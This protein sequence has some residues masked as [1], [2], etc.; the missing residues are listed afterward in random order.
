[1]ASSSQS[2]QPGGFLQPALPSPPASS[3]NSPRI[4]RPVLPQPRSKPLKPG[5]TKESNFIDHVE[6]KLLAV[7]RRYENRFSATLS[8]EENP[9]IEGRGYKNIGDEVR[10]LDPIVDVVWISGTRRVTLHNCCKKYW[11]DTN[12]P[13]TA[14]LQVA[15]LL[16]IALTVMTSLPSFPF[17]PRPTFQLLQKLDL[18]FASLLRGVNAE[19][20]EALP[21]SETGKS[22]L[23]TT[24]KIR[25]RGIVEKTRLAVVE[26][27]GKDESLADVSNN[28]QSMM[29]D[30][31]DDF[32]ATMTEDEDLDDLEDES[33]HRRWEMDIARVYERTI[34]ELGLALD[35][36]DSGNDNW[37]L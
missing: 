22:R 14:S 8:E 20:G 25:I 7:S 23:S 15:F 34:V 35:V 19:T 17:M 13:S 27:A 21:G 37:V 16:T 5:S 29:T 36:S 6:Q 2:Q 31:E 9:D 12:S 33:S 10:D 1:M 11:I 26:V 30:T 3:V 28:S 4:P 18:V 24:E 32:N